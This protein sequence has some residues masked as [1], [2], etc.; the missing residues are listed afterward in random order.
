MLN[1]YINREDA[2]N[3]MEVM[4]NNDALFN[5]DLYNGL[6]VTETIKK[7]MKSIDNAEYIQGMDMRSRYGN[8]TSM[9]NLSTGCKTAIN[10]INHPEL[11]I[12]CV[13]CGDNVLHKIIKSCNKGNVLFTFLP[14]NKD[15]GISINM[16]TA[17]GGQVVNNLNDFIRFANEYRN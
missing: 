14:S 5:Y 8:I 15:K 17:Q 9:E 1:V 11:I 7:I 4:N 16:V 13:E 3:T 12:D 6:T 2:E 10:I